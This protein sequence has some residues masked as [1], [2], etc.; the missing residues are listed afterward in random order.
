MKKTQIIGHRGAKG[1]VAF[2]NTIESFQKA[3]DVGC[4]GIEFDIRKTL[5]NKI[6]VHH[7]DHINNN[8]IKNHTYDDLLEISH[9]IGYHIPLLEEVLTKFK[10]KIYFDIEIKEYG[11]EEDVIKLIKN[12]LDYHEFCVRSFHDY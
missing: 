11:Y 4:D 8:L 9:K 5:D 2:E 3:I 6:I 10:G 12:F 7:D 1:L